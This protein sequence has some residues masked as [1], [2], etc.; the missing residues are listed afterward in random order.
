MKN[1]SV[2]IF[3]LMEADG[4]LLLRAILLLCPINETE[5][6]SY[7]IWR[8]YYSKTNMK[9]AP[10]AAD[11]SSKRQRR[12]L[13]WRM[14]PD[15]SFSDFA[16]E[17]FREGETDGAIYHVHK[18]TLA[19]GNRSSG[20]FAALFACRT[21]ESVGNKARIELNTKSANAFPLLLD[22]VYGSDDPSLTIR[23]SGPLYHLADYF[24]VERLRSEVTEFWERSTKVEDLGT[25]LDQ[26]AMFQIDPL[27]EI[28]VTRCAESIDKISLDSVL[29]HLT[30][31]KFW[32]DVRSGMKE[33]SKLGT[34]E[35]YWTNLAAQFCFIEK[36]RMEAR[37]ITVNH[38]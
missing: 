33:L 6:N 26:A 15:Q 1:G 28:I 36:D 31:A 32:I 14:H 23:S 2:L 18:A 29:L 4:S 25:C 16:I 34:H 10:A 5:S 19:Y 21:A 30:D 17:I 9:R 13:D 11:R 12:A 22:Y 38:C 7:M 3:S 24:D 37:S 35:H 27:K 8:E 20:Y